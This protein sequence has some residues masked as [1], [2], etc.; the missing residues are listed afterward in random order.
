LKD[1]RYQYAALHFFEG[2]WIYATPVEVN[3]HGSKV[4]V[5]Y[6]N[7]KGFESIGKLNVYDDRLV[8]YN[9]VYNNSASLFSGSDLSCVFGPFVFILGY[10][11]CKL[12]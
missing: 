6:L 5:L 11:F 8:A 12:F 1:W 2:I 10:L 9:K 3:V 7:T 4:S